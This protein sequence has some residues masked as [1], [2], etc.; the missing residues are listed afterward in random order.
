[1]DA[2]APDAVPDNR[3]FV[4]NFKA[5]IASDHAKHY[6]DSLPGTQ[7]RHIMG[8]YTPELL[9]VLSGLARQY[10][11]CDRWFSSVPTMTMPNRAFA[12][13]GPSQGHLDDHTKPFT[14]PSIFGALE[15]Q[16]LDWAIF[17]YNREPLTRL[18]FP[19]T[20]HADESH[21][22][23]FGDFQARAAAGTLP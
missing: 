10:A 12:N 3:G 14:C 23:R 21:F 16:G 1:T 9:P 11:V 13:A 7:A 17:G 19:D 8:M 20:L 15:A 2:P 6:K 5:A 4:K 22:G 18:D